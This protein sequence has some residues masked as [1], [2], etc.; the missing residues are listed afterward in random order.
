MLHDVKLP[1]CAI[2]FEAIK[3]LQR[4]ML[5]F[6]CDPAT[7]NPLTQASVET[8]FGAQGTWMWE[9]LYNKAGQPTDLGKLVA[10]VV[11]YAKAHYNLHHAALESFDHDTSYHEHIEDPTFHF[12][13]VTHVEKEA[14][15]RIRPLMEAFYEKL[16]ASGFP[17]C[18][19]GFTDTFHR[20]ALVRAF[21][22]ANPNLRVCPACG[23][24][25]PDSIGDKVF[26]DTDHF[27]PKSL[28]PF[29][30]VHAV[31]LLPICVP[32]NRSF[33]LDID[34][35][36]NGANVDPMDEKASAP[37]LHTFLPYLRPAI[38]AIDLRVQRNAH[39]V[40]LCTIFDNDGTQT[41]RVKNLNRVLKLESR[42]SSR[43]DRTI[44][45]IRETLALAGR[46][47]R[48]YSGTET[49]EGLR[50]ELTEMRDERRRRVAREPDFVIQGEYLEYAL[51]EEA[52]F[53][54]LFDNYSGGHVQRARVAAPV[55][56]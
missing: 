54:E 43:L 26:A 23:G 35:A 40:P 38:N 41:R 52:E 48:R 7:P 36:N 49:I 12:H 4:T 2:Q 1:D 11:D 25:P 34:A 29:L 20:D 14:R 8:K 50:L 32:C 27:L 15:D 55:D 46:R 30:S 53:A 28:Y 44:E 3:Q 17:Q 45:S 47:Q 22:K 31:N 33:K 5:D 13:Y 19:H 24:A 39:N 37:L 18:V 42:W 6:A 16:L 56:E 51:H 9:R 10:T 21:W